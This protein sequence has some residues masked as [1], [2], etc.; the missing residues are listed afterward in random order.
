MGVSRRKPLAILS[1]LLVA[2]SAAVF[3]AR[4]S[5][6]SV[7]ADVKLP[8]LA[9]AGLATIAG[10]DNGLYQRVLSRLEERLAYDPDDY[11]ASLVK[12]LILFKSGHLPEARAELAALTR[13]APKFQLAQL[14]QGDLLL[15]QTQTVT[16]IGTTPVLADF[17]PEEE[18]LKQLRAEAELRLKAYIDALPQDRLPRSLLQLGPGVDNAIVVDKENHRLYVYQRQAGDA[19]PK[20]VRD[21]YVSTGKLNGNKVLSGD[22]RTP[23]GVYF[24]TRHIPDSA[25]PEKYGRGA[26]PLNYPNELDAHFGKTGTGIW[27]HGTDGAFYARPPQDSEGCVVLP[28]ED[29]KRVGAFIHPGVTPLVI[30]AR[31]D[32]IDEATWR[33]ERGELA[34][35]LDGW[36]ADW[37]SGDVEKYLGHYAPDF[38]TGGADLR[39]WQERKRA[40]A[41]GKDYQKVALSGL[42]LFAYPRSATGGR[43]V[44]VADFQQHYRSNNLTSDLGKRLYLARVDGQWRVLYEGNQ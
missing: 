38:W 2:T 34:A 7:D 28:N 18:A 3:G 39:S 15:A 11:E 27:L 26:Y 10:E 12:G 9:G 22:L 19:P 32:W 36:A 20:L 1:V 37:S 21:F 41:Q 4:Q 44:V 16:D 23:E 29:L 40:V 35:A 6:S 30:T 5:L 13:R 25:L 24:L 17:G 8:G 14:V 42:S 43:E 31:V 33:R